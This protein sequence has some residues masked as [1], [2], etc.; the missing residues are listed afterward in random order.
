MFIFLGT[1]ALGFIFIGLVGYFI[2]GPKYKGPVSDHFDGRRFINPG[3]IKA[4]GFREV[5]KWMVARKQG[6]WKEVPAGQGEK[7]AS[8]FDNGIRIT[9]VNHSTFLIQVDGV[10]ILT[11]PVFS[12]RTS[13]VQWAGPRRMRPPGILLED[14]P[15]IDV[16]ILSHNHWDHL[17]IAAVKKIHA[18]HHPKIIT[19]LGVKAFLDR[20]GVTGAK[21]VDWWQDEEINTLLKIQSVPAQHFSGRGTFDRDATLWCGY[22]IRRR[23]GNIY[24]AG[25]TG[26]NDQ[27][28]KE[29]GE[30]CA[31]IQVAL[32][33]IGAYKPRWF[34]SPI[35]CSPEEAVKIHQEVRSKNSIATHFGTFP[36][37]DDGQREPVVELNKALQESGIDPETFL[38]LKEGV[39]REF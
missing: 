26:Y 30:R 22:M 28:F 10:N 29:I 32:L 33:P 31:P 11:D 2:S 23:G 34:M 18:L 1:F 13:P 37:A 25:D 5:L 12:E 9:F 8:R 16:L 39:P 3:S 38:V 6:E 4:K 19:P 14:L 24:F 15:A 36:L 17:D 35:H 20:E 27:T 7:P 21:D